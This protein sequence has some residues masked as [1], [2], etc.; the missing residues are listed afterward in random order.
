MSKIKPK[1]LDFATTYLRDNAGQL[2]IAAA[3]AAN[4]HTQ[5]SDTKLANGT[6][7]EVT[8]AELRAFVDSK[9]SASGLASLDSSGK[10]PTGQLPALA[11]SDSFVVASQAAMLALT[12]EV[13]DVAIRT[14]LNKSFILHTAGASTLGNWQELL[15]PTSA[16]TSVNGA[17]GAV[18]LAAGDIGYSGISSFL[19]ATTVQGAI[20]E[21]EARLDTAQSNI[22]TLQSSVTTLQASSA[23]DQANISS[24]QS[25]MS[26]AQADIAA[27][28]A[29]DSTQNTNITALQARSN[30]VRQFV[31]LS[32]G[33]IS[34]KQVTLSS[35]PTAIGAIS[36]TIKG[37]GCQFPTDD[38]SL[39]SGKI[40]WNNSEGMDSLG[41]VAGD[42]LL[43]EYTI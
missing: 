42:K 23:T 38:F 25:Q 7:N 37:I 24:L 8:A 31:S 36:V 30:I 35:T 6:S 39:V 15:T 27:T 2:D 20:D 4:F 41:L 32:S 11:I 40:D 13:G 9:A 5:N 19:S 3:T 1:G 12:A 34:A 14:D 29:V 22:T 18:T 43:I 21:V 17:T 16:V 26:S 10:I 28:Q 33:Q